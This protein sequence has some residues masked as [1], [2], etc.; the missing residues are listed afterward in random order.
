MVFISSITKNFQPQIGL[1]CWNK[2]K[3]VFFQWISNFTAS[4]AINSSELRIDLVRVLIL[5]RLPKFEHALPW[6]GRQSKFIFSHWASIQWKRSCIRFK[7]SYLKAIVG[8][9]VEST[10]FGEIRPTSFIHLHIS[11]SLFCRSLLC[12]QNI[13]HEIQKERRKGGREEER[14]E[15][16]VSLFLF[17]FFFI[18]CLNF[19][20][21]PFEINFLTSWSNK[22]LW[23][24]YV[25]LK[26][27][28][29]RS[30]NILYSYTIEILC[31]ILIQLIFIWNWI[32]E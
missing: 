31:N 12:S 27:L 25:N 22:K 19:F 26:V 28:D 10:I 1:K 20:L 23:W 7:W 11:W 16:L 4:E 9:E 24:L 30:Y 3:L 13:F 6:N 5:S 8:K 29:K 14:W 17:F 32:G 18:T 15:V 2:N 21:I